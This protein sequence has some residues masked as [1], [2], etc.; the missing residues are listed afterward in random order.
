MND[1]SQRIDV[2]EGAPP[3]L[4]DRLVAATIARVHPE[5]RRWIDP[6]TIRGHL[7]EEI[8]LAIEHCRDRARAER[9]ARRCPVQGAQT[10]DYRGQLLD[11]GDLVVLAGLRFKGLD[12]GHPFVELIAAGSDL[13]GPGVLSRCCAALMQAYRV[14]KPRSVRIQLGAHQP[15]EAAAASVEVE[16]DLRILVGPIAELQTSPKPRHYDAITIQRC[17]D[18]GFYDRY[19]RTLE[20][21]RRERPHLAESL[22]VSTKEDMQAL[23]AEGH[24][25]EAWIDERW[26]G[27]IAAASGRY[28]G[29]DGFVVHEELLIPELRGQGY[30]APLQRHLIDRLDG[31]DGAL[32]YGTIHHANTASLRTARRCGRID[33]GGYYFTSPREASFV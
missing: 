6:E 27:L 7:R 30:G 22:Y 18:L 17:S 28:M 16:P 31:A 10:G 29:R 5:L 1:L 4:R 14:F 32:L 25:Y 23:L 12:V 21:A 15:I 26:G 9:V 8:D 11:L 19:Q 24:T 3:E 2:D 20:A 33:V 13:L